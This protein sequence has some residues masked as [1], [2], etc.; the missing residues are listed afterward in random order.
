MGN[1]TLRS[2]VQ[3]VHVDAKSHSCVRVRLGVVY[4]YR[5]HLLGTVPGRGMVSFS[6]LQ[7][8]AVLDQAP[9]PQI[10]IE[11][12]LRTHSTRDFL[13]CFP[14]DLP[15]YISEIGGVAEVQGR[16]DLLPP[17]RIWSQ[18]HI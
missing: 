1:L 11:R 14:G 13:A 7:Y 9:N 10:K 15:F 18:L 2:I 17:T 4:S 6:V 8:H 16:V 3:G 5:Y 12:L